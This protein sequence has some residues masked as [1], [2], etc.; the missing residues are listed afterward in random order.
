MN[1]KSMNRF[2]DNLNRLSINITDSDF[3]MAKEYLEELDINPEEIME[4]GV[5]VFKRISFLAKAKANQLRDE[6]LIA[7]LQNKIQ[8][9]FVLNAKL[10]G[11]ILQNALS[12]KNIAFQF[13]NLEK[14]SEDEI[15]E[16]LGDIDLVKLLE[17]LENMNE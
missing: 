12:E 14:W 1:K 2:I 8:E 3:E 9:S 6:S 10:T 16:V 15:R 17:D 4:H 13:R 11:Q 7:R 5:N